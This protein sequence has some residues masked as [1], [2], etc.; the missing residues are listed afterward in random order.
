MKCG[1]DLF[2]IC[3]FISIPNSSHRSIE[4]A[5]SKTKFAVCE[6]KKFRNIENTFA[7]TGME[8]YK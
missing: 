3:V 2:A 4:R 8:W 7:K 6:K 5:E 1:C